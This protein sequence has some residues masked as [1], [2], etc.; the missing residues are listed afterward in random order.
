[1]KMTVAGKAIMCYKHQKK[2]K[3]LH[4]ALRNKKIN[5]VILITARKQC[6]SPLGNLTTTYSKTLYLR[7]IVPIES[8]CSS[9][10]TMLYA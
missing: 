3:V 5:K 9:H 1:M 8:S 6:F 10:P 4:F 2:M 7:Q